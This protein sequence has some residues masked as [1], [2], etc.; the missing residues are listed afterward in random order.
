MRNSRL[1][2]F[3][4]LLSS[5]LL[6]WVNA[7]N[8]ADQEVSDTIRDHIERHQM[9]GSLVAFG[10]LSG[11]TGDEMLR[12]K[13]SGV[14][15]KSQHLVGNAI[16]VRLRGLDTKVLRDYA[17]NLNLGGVCYYASSNFVHVDTGRVRY[18]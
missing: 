12:N 14:A 6:L 9:S 10:N 13:S 3:L 5:S 16:D 17:K 2:P 7:V 15:E 1:L 8:A 18:W 4:C 11:N